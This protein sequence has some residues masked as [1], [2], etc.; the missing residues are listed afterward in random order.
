VIY[1]K[2][3]FLSEVSYGEVLGDKS[4]MHIRVTVY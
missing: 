2:C 4:A 1:V 3:F